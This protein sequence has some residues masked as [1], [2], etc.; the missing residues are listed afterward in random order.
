MGKVVWNGTTSAWATAANWDTGVAPVANDDVIFDS[1][2]SH[3]V[4]GAD[5]SAIDLDSIT[6]TSRYKGNLGTSG[7]PLKLTGDRAVIK[8]GGNECWIDGAFDHAN[9]APASSSVNACQW[10]GS[11]TSKQIVIGG[12]HVVLRSGTVYTASTDI[13]VTPEFAT[14]AA[15]TT[16]IIEAGQ[17]FAATMRLLV[18]GGLVVMDDC[19]STANSAIF[20]MGGKVILQEAGGTTTSVLVSGGILQHDDGTVT[21][22]WV[23]A[24]GKWD[25]SQSAV[26]TRVVTTMQIHGPEAQA[27]FRNGTGTGFPATMRPYSNPKILIDTPY[28][29]SLSFS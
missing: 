14:G 9:L 8:T 23:G 13:S 20:V 22:A 10:G 4:A 26:G 6:V 2:S 25:A 27:D 17:T 1:M 19:L 3:D 21:L 29:M 24:R 5:L 11:A 16:V 15:G 7:V 18:S 28:D 12:G